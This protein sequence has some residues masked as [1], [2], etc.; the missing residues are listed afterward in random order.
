MKKKIFPRISP[1]LLAGILLILL[2]IF[3]L[4]TL[5]RLERQKEF[6]SQRLI[7]KGTFLIRTFEAGTRTGL[8][9]M[10]WGAKRIQ[11]MLYETSLQPEVVYLMIAAKDGRI[12][13]HSDASLVG[14]IFEDMPKTFDMD[15]DIT[16]IFH[17]VRNLQTADQVFEVYKRFVPVRSSGYKGG[18]HRHMRPKPLPEM[19]DELPKPLDHK[20]KEDWSQAYTGR[21]DETVSD[22]TEHYI[23][24]GLSMEKEKA[25][26]IMMVRQTI[27]RGV[28]FFILGCAGIVALLA[29]QAYRGTKASLK[30]IKAFSDNVIHHMPSGL[31]TFDADHGITS[32]NQAA[33]QIFG[34]DRQRSFSQW[35]ELMEEIASSGQMISREMVFELG[36]KKT[37][38]LDITASPVMD[39]QN[40]ISGFLFLFKDLTQIKDLKMKVETNKRLAAIG[41]LAAGVAHEI[42]NPLSS[43]KGFATYFGKRYPDN[44]TDRQTARIMVNEVDRINTSVTQLLEFAKPMA[45]EKKQVDIQQMIHHSLKL[46]QYDMDQKQIESSVVI[47]TQKTSV[48]TDE[49]RMNQVLLNLYINAIQAMESGGKLSVRVSDARQENWIKIQVEDNGCGMDPETRD[50]IFDPYFTTRSSGTGLG[51]AIVYRIIENLSGQIHVKSTV[52]QGSCFTISL[53]AA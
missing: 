43:I 27:V 39:D 24:A 29:F 26:R 20:G 40:L 38:L 44:E 28:F 32:M 16:R 52:G 10:R 9:T 35:F 49:G 36:D 17:R 22:K 2:P 34:N 7:E 15:E 53:P 1:L 47:D 25:A 51:L 33:E 11:T 41:K 14:Q 50:L 46:V 30:Q 18:M 12:L 48:Y 45:L 31:I 6:F 21:M 19:G 3:T 23:F 37:V 8:F 42:R 4:M 13:A 5:D